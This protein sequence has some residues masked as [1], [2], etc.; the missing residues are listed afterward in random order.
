METIYHMVINVKDLPNG[1][2]IPVLA[3]G[4]E[5]IDGVWYYKVWDNVNC[6]DCQKH[7]LDKKSNS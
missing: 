5:P 2:P 3:C 7:N 1:K 6:S 4:V